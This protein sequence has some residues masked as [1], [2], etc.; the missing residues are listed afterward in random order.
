MFAVLHLTH[1]NHHKSKDDNLRQVDT[2][3]LKTDMWQSEQTN[4]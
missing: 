1:T 4:F 3:S 2:V